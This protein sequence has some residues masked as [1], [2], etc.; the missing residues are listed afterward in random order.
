MNI[1]PTTD[2]S[3]GTSPVLGGTPAHNESSHASE[4]GGALNAPL[5]SVCMPVYNAKRYLGEAIDSILG[6]TFR[7]FEFLI[8]NDGST[9]RSLTILKRYAAQDSRIRL[10]T[11]PNAGYV[12]RLNE[13]LHQARGDLIARMD[14]DDVAL[15]ER[16]TR[17]VEFLRSHPD[18]DVVGGAQEHINSKGHLLNVHYDPLGHEEIL[19]HGMTGACPMNHPSVMMRRKA[20]LT[21]G[22]YQAEMM[23][24][25][26][27]DLWLRMGERGRL[28]NLPDVITQYR[29][30]DSSVSAVLQRQQLNRMQAA[31]DGACD[32]RGIPRRKLELE[33]WRPVDRRSKHQFVMRHGW[34]GFHRGDQPAAVHFGLRAVRL[35]PW[36]RDSWLL[37]AC[38]ILKIKPAKGE[39][40]RPSPR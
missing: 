16:F 6:Q 11:R 2:N 23:P 40:C 36:R 1:T 22:G 29:L 4:Q 19:E 28:A 10:S 17:Q 33:P 5:I 31:V 14:A 27:L 9:D 35:M 38:A 12:V 7:D 32:R 3:A 20:V 25:E 39:M 30:H 37:L 8:I 13:M 24:A 26:D 21:V 18:V 34:G 15:P